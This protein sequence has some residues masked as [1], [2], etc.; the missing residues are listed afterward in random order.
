M[1]LRRATVLG[2]LLVSLAASAADTAPRR[3]VSLNLCVDQLLLELVSPERIASITWLSRSEGD[4][5]LMPLARRLPINHGGA[6][7]VLAARPDLVIAGRFTT[8]TT[9][10]LLRRAGIPLLEVD[11]AQDWEGIRSVTRV[12][13]EAVHE[14]VR[15]ET[16]LAQMDATLIAL[17][18]HRPEVPI[19]VI[20]WAGGANDVPG[21]DTLF[22]TLL[23]SAGGINV[24]AI[25]GGRGG[26][27]VE[28]VI[29]QRPQALLRGVSYGATPALRNEAARHRLLQRLYPQGQLT[30]SEA[31]FGCGVPRAAS[32]AASLQASLRSM[33]ATSVQR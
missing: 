21:T 30:Y 9:R 20:G 32:A 7:E 2:L 24:G 27:D 22:N 11:P 3:I 29:R 6:E 33:A 14:T 26:F 4:E 12:I 17:E 25:E 8:S 1:A 16:L 18:R 13:A 19:R 23:V 28:R 10:A 5:S 31:L 15:A